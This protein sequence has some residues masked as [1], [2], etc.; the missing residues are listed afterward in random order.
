MGSIVEKLYNNKNFNNFYKKTFLGSLLRK[1]YDFFVF[2][3]WECRTLFDV[4]GCFFRRI[5][6]FAK[7]YR[8]LKNI[9]NHYKGKRCFITCTG[10][11]LTIEDLEL[12]SDEFVF[13]MNSI[14][15]I[16]DKTK[17]RPDFFAIQD[18][19]VYEK[20]KS[21]LWEEDLGQI[22]V[23]S[24]YVRNDLVPDSAIGFHISY[25]Y[26]MFDLYRRHNYFAKFSDNSYLTVY[27]GYS[28]TYSIMQLAVYM[29]FDEIYLIGADCSYLGQQQH[30]IE[31]GSYDPTAKTATE[32]LLAAYQEAKKYSEK[33]NV[34]F[35]NAT[36]GGCLELFERVK[37][38]DVLAD[39]KKNKL[40]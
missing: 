40:S 13:G 18:L 27:D 38:E 8:R 22:F 32:R 35:Y 21:K 4:L 37:L 11:S 19:T 39:S 24:Y 6:L 20:V 33:H 30:F 16:G 29:G 1:I 12:L 9:K 14:C 2:I 7:D 36:R 34:K 23:P 26:H 28:I 5:N 25:S 17:W 15:L 3:Y 31:H 10:P